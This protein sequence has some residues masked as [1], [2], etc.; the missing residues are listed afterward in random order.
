M[1]IGIIFMALMAATPAAAHQEVVLAASAL[2]M[3][4]G[5]VTITLASLAAWRDRFR[6]DKGQVSNKAETSNAKPNGCFQPEAVLREEPRVESR[7]LPPLQ[8]S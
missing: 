2:P 6:A 4:A 5:L 1:K 8:H 7:A 3:A